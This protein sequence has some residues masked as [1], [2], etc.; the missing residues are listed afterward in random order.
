MCPSAQ[1]WSFIPPSYE[2]W[3]QR[4]FRTL[5]PSE[6][7]PCKTKSLSYFSLFPH[8]SPS[9]FRLILCGGRITPTAAQVLREL[10]TLA[11][12]VVFCF[13]AGIVL[14]SRFTLHCHPHIQ[15]VPE[16]LL[17]LIAGIGGRTPGTSLVG[18]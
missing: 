15:V 3:Y 13:S 17:Y 6:T 9:P 12:E 5:Q 16:D 8:T 2:V 7:G 18:T 1:L 4:W 10:G 11:I 14:W